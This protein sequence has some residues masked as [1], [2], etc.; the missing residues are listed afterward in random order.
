MSYS[1]IPHN[2]NDTMDDDID[3]ASGSWD[4]D[5]YREDFHSD[6]AIGLVYYSDE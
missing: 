6:D 3:A 5:D 1:D 2:N 4:I